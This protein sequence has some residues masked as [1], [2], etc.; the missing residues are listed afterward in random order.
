VEE[1]ARSARQG[2][3]SAEDALQQFYARN[4]TYQASPTLMFEEG[5]L[6]RRVDLAQSLY[7]SLA[8]QLQQA[9]INAA[10]DT[11]VYSVVDAPAIPGLRAFPRRTKSVALAGLLGLLIAS[12]FI[13]VRTFYFGD[14]ETKVA[15]SIEVHA[16]AVDAVRD[17][18]RAYSR[19]VRRN[20]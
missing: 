14:A 8:Q 5:R 1:E 9:K 7:V 12:G 19:F 18:R 13:F 3:D 4:R 10:Q 16:A 15:A 20:R 2:L 17:M 6:K 11:P